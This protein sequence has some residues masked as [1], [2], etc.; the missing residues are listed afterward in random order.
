MLQERGYD[1]ISYDPYTGAEPPHRMFLEKCVAL[2]GTKH[3]EFKTTVGRLMN[4]SVIIDPWRYI[5][6]TARRDIIRIGE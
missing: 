2:V 4:E 1:V 6:D 5:P 3:P